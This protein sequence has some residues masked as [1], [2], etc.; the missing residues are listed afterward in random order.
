MYSMTTSRRDGIALPSARSRTGKGEH[1]GLSGIL[2]L[3]AGAMHEVIRGPGAGQL[4][5]TLFQ[6]KGGRGVFILI[7]LDGLVVDEVCDVQKHLA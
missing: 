7:P 4:H 5:A 3:R 2:L 6:L 1:D